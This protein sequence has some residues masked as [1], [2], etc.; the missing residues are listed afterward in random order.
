MQ[1]DPRYPTDEPLAPARTPTRTG[2]LAMV[3]VPAAV[4]LAGTMPEF[5]AG[6]A[7]TALVVAVRDRI[8]A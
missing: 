7:A 5:T 1:S 6:V 8:R 2:A 3:A 4:V